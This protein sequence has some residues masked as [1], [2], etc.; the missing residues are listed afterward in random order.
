[1]I[2]PLAVVLFCVGLLS[3]KSSKDGGIFGPTDQT[4]EAAELVRE[5]NKDLTEIKKLYDANE[6]TAD[7]PGTRLQLKKALEENNAEQVK[8]ISD[9]VVYLIKDGMDFAKSAID[10]V[11]RAQDMNISDD[12]KDYLRLKEMALTKQVEAFEEYRQAARALRD[13]Y[14]PK[15]D[16]LRAKVKIEFD[17]RSDKYRELMETARSFSSEA[18]EKAKEAIR[19]DAQQ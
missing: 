1:M 19:R 10:K 8:K 6:G 13:N 9:D 11:Q 3:C 18:N 2:V 14:D 15:N 16:Q 17:Q 12:Y 5:A 7:K 4:Q